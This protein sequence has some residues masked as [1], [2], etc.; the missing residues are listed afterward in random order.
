MAGKVSRRCGRSG[1]ISADVVDYADVGFVDRP[2]FQNDSAAVRMY[3]EPDGAQLVV[4]EE[5]RHLGESCPVLTTRISPPQ[6]TPEIR[7]PLEEQDF[8]DARDGTPDGPPRE[9]LFAHAVDCTDPNA[10]V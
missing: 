3:V 7:F 9:D 8:A 5:E 6:N 10:R 2:R 4:P 1:P